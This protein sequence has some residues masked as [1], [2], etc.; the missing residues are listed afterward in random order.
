MGRY[1]QE[2]KALYE[3]FRSQL[4]QLEDM[5]SPQQSLFRYDHPSTSPV[6]FF[7]RAHE[8]VQDCDYC[9]VRFDLEQ[10][11]AYSA[12]LQTC[13]QR[14]MQDQDEQSQRW[15]WTDNCQFNNHMK[16]VKDKKPKVVIDD[17]LPRS[18]HQFP[19]EITSKIYAV[20]DLESYV[21]LR[22]VGCE[23][24]TDFHCIDDILE[25][26]MTARNPW[27]KPRVDGLSTWRDC[28]L[29]FAARRT[30][31]KWI[32]LNSLDNIEIPDKFAERKIVVANELSLDEKL[33]PDFMGMI[34]HA[35][36]M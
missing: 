19:F 11:L 10:N 32:A 22:Q 33:P 21:S 18:G 3:T 28:V 23:C 29:V 17:T 30:H 12:Q 34:V 31:P 2:F 9:L 4:K 16:P 6:Q 24:Y 5:L 15:F 13:F 25:A 20:A 35:L 27:M 26:K 7:K 8:I 36:R 14:M 1:V